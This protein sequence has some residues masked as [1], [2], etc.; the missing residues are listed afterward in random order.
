[1]IDHYFKEIRRLQFEIERAA[2]WQIEKAPLLMSDLIECLVEASAFIKTAPAA[3]KLSS[4][5]HEMRKAAEDVVKNSNYMAHKMGY[6]ETVFSIVPNPTYLHGPIQRLINNKGDEESLS[7]AR[8]AIRLGAVYLPEHSTAGSSLTEDRDIPVDVCKGLLENYINGYWAYDLEKFNQHSVRGFHSALLVMCADNGESEYVI[9]HLERARS[10]ILQ[11]ALIFSGEDT[12]LTSYKLIVQDLRNEE[13]LVTISSL[14]P[15]LYQEII[16]ICE[17]QILD[18]IIDPHPSRHFDASRLPPS[19]SMDEAFLSHAM[20]RLSGKGLLTT[21]RYESLR[22]CWENANLPGTL[23]EFC[24]LSPMRD[25]CSYAREH[26]K[27]VFAKQTL[28]SLYQLGN[29]NRVPHQSLLILDDIYSKSVKI[30]D[31][32]AALDNHHVMHIFKQAEIPKS[33]KVDGEIQLT[34]L[35]LKAC[36]KL[37]VDSQAYGH[38]Q[39]KEIVDVVTQAFADPAHYDSIKDI[40]LQSLGRIR[41]ACKRITDEDVRKIQWQ[42]LQIN[43][44]LFTEDLGL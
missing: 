29:L 5:E 10:T 39:S 25:Q 3:P 12:V 11:D 24:K 8:E 6:L 15:K 18:K 32:A 41:Q 21:E 43:G 9:D 36:L 7:L 23:A 16:E 44:E 28:S 4:L 22:K 17:S 33:A 14:N 19:K 38:K 13:A 26:R 27:N 31:D 34:A 30:R 40:S 20:D 37:I 1:M 2:Q 35:M 42:D